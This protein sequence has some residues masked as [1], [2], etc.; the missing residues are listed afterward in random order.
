M[1]S[2]E[3]QQK[4]KR[5]RLRSNFSSISSIIMTKGNSKKVIIDHKT[6]VKLSLH[7]AGETVM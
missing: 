5:M 7:D 1:T 3:P 2:N 6:N 4:K